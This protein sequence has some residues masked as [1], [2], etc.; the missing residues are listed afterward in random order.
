[1][2]STFFMASSWLPPRD[3]EF[4]AGFD[5]GRYNPGMRR[6]TRLG[7]VIAVLLLITG[8]GAYT[9][10]WFIVAGKLEDGLKEWAQSARD[11]KIET[12][13]RG[14]R[15]GGFPFAFRVELTEAALR[16]EAINPAAEIR[17]PLLS[18][19]THPWSFRVWHL[20]APQGLNVV[21]GTEGKPVAK[22]AARAARGA[23]S[24]ASEGGATIWLS[25]DEARFAAGEEVGARDAHFWLILPSRPPE[26][27]TENNLAVAADLREATVPQMP[28]PFR[29]LVDELAF[30]ITVKGAIAAGPARQAAAAWRDSGGTVELDNFALRWAKLAITG[31]GTLALD[32]DLQPI[33][34]FSGAVEGYDELMSALVA[35]GGMKPS[36]ARLA[37][38]ALAMLA[39][40]GPDGRPA[41]ATSFTIQN[42][43]MFLGPAKLGPAP[44]IPWD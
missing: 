36:D 8:I 12:S 32:A 2:I 24:A 29:N 28:S 38:I 44:K 22:L 33:G 40:A 3:P 5:G 30:G 39:K 14:L 7:I 11:Q 20:T 13:W 35:A 19:S 4:K 43:Q 25:L 15:V 16:D 26:T 18:A 10:F 17:M 31:S 1:V 6:R 34:G 27:H 37:R 42:G 21:A 23:V 9:A 41:I